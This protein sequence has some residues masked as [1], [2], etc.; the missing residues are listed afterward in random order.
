MADEKKTL[1]ERWNA[2]NPFYKDVIY[3]A[4]KYIT[5]LALASLATRHVI[6]I[7]Q[8][9]ELL[10]NLTEKIILG[11]VA[12][13]PFALVVLK[14]IQKRAEYMTALMVAKMTENET[15]TMVKDSAVPTPTVLTS[16]STIPGVPKS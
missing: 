5:G 7:D 12:M 10:D 4:V 15:K 9:R 16:P 1:I 11:L 3:S 13:A 2:V 8:S 14:M 6:T